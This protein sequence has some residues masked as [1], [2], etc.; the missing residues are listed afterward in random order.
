[1]DLSLIISV[2]RYAAITL[3]MASPVGIRFFC[4]GGNE[5]MKNII[6]PANIMTN[7]RND[8]DHPINDREI[9]PS[10]AY[11]LVFSA[12]TKPPQPI[13]KKLNKTMTQLSTVS[14]IK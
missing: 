4:R 2:A 12:A 9:Q 13:S 11:A 6:H 14:M 10:L 5:S 3:R 1:M 7:I 8:V